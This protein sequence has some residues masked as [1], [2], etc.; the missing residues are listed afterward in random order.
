M[1]LASPVTLFRWFCLYSLIAVKLLFFKVELKSSEDSVSKY[2][3]SA[4]NGTH[5]SSCISDITEFRVQ[6]LYK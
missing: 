5:S 2:C 1:L 6:L 3:L 4:Q